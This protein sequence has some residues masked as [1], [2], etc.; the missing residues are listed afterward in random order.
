MNVKTKLKT[1]SIIT[2][3]VYLLII[4]VFVVNM[5]R[6]DDKQITAE[7]NFVYK[8]ESSIKE[9]LIQDN[10]DDIKSQLSKLT[11]EHSLEIAVDDGEKVIYST[12]PHKVGMNHFDTVNKNA[13]LA[14]SQTSLETPYGVR[15]VWY[16]MYTLSD[17]E[18]FGS[19]FANQAILMVIAF[20]VLSGAIAYLGFYVIKPMIKIRESIEQASNFNFETI[21]PDTDAVNT[22]FYQ[23]TG[24]LENKLGL[25]S[26]QYTELEKQ[27]QIN[28]EH[29]K[30]TLVVSR[31]FIHD[32]K[33]PLHQV[34][35]ENDFYLANL[36]YQSEELIELTAINNSVIEKLIKNIN[37]VLLIMKNDVY[38]EL[39]DKETIDLEELMYEVIKMFNTHIKNKKLSINLEFDNDVHVYSNKTTIRLLLHNLI[40]NMIQYSKENSEASITVFETSESIEISFKNDSSEENIKRMK[41]SESIFNSIPSNDNQFS[42]GN[43]LFLIKDLTHILG[44]EYSLIQSDSIVK[45]IISIPKE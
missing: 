18:V 9:A 4:V 40:S 13:V 39:K 20:V 33:T 7:Y 43:G 36:P 45:V 35:L 32:L 38:Q 24:K 1:L 34:I 8:M 37:E 23:F 14:E 31:S 42:G 5:L 16:L 28:K 15:N 27:L 12:V 6:F 3:T 25:V 21:T 19:Y 22:E 41:M 30:N 17:T 29:L 26:R 11:D 10:Y 2:A 44:G